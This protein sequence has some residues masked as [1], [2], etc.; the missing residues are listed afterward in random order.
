MSS[1]NEKIRCKKCHERGYH[2][3]DSI[4]IISICDYCGGRGIIDWID[5]M[6]GNPSPLPFDRSIKEK[7]VMKNVE[8]LMTEIKIMLQQIDVQA[9]VQVIHQPIPHNHNYNIA[10]FLISQ[11]PSPINKVECHTYTYPHPTDQKIIFSL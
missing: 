9:T 7:I 2:T 8:C 3:R 11:K 10:P 5:H 4:S 6:T 1:L